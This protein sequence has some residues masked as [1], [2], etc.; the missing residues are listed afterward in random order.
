MSYIMGRSSTIPT[1][2]RPSFDLS[3]NPRTGIPIGMPR[4]SSFRISWS[5]TEITCTPRI[6]TTASST[7]TLMKTV[8]LSRENLIFP[9]AMQFC[10]IFF[11]YNRLV[12]D[13]WTAVELY[14]CNESRCS[15]NARPTSLE[16]KYRQ[17]QIRWNVYRL[18]RF[19][20]RPQCHGWSYENT[21]FINSITW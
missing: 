14:S 12:G 10:W 17:S 19:V 13:L 4:S 8:S 1:I 15:F 6:I 16:H 20:R 3:F 7:L 9:F 21:V 11:F 2:D 5:E 18:W